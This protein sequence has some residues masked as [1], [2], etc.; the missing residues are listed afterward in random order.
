M[1]TR[2]WEGYFNRLKG[3][4]EDLLPRYKTDAPL[5]SMQVW[6]GIICLQNT[7]I[8]HLSPWLGFVKDAA[9][10]IYLQKYCM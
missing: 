2:L 3:L 7:V 6:I 1:D 9:E 10:M 5:V 4:C 8:K